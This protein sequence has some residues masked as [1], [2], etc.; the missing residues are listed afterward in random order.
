MTRADRWRSRTRNPSGEWRVCIGLICIM[1]MTRRFRVEIYLVENAP[2]GVREKNYTAR[3]KIHFLNA[4]RGRADRRGD[5]AVFMKN[6]KPA[7]KKVFEKMLKIFYENRPR[8]H[9]AGNDYANGATSVR[10]VP[11]MCTLRMLMSIAGII[12]HHI[13]RN[14]LHLFPHRMI[15]VPKDVRFFPPTF[16]VYFLVY[17]PYEIYYVSTND[18]ICCKKLYGVFNFFFK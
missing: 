15:S 8:H 5:T 11:F 17:A 12:K 16:T 9:L 4:R 1:S 13:I 2:K 18:F 6:K 7:D 14:P 10:G 3:L